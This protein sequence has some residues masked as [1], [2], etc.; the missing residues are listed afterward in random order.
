MTHEHTFTHARNRLQ[1]NRTASFAHNV[2]H[3]PFLSRS[4]NAAFSNT[5]AAL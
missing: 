2:N 1:L 4:K 5:I 3:S